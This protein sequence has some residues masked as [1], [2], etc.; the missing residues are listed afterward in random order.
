MDVFLKDAHLPVQSVCHLFKALINLL[1]ALSLKKNKSLVKMHHP[2]V[3]Q[4][5]GYVNMVM[6]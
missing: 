2:F 4:L 6:K 5:N 1:K 3:Q